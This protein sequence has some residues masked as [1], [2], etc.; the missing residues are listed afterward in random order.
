MWEYRRKITILHTF[1][2]SPLS[3][4]DPSTEV[5]LPTQNPLDLTSS[6]GLRL[7][8][9]PPSYDL[10]R[11]VSVP[12]VSL[13]VPSVVVVRSLTR[14]YD[15]PEWTTSNPST[16]VGPRVPTYPQPDDYQPDLKITDLPRPISFPDSLNLLFY[17]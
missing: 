6:P 12:T 10:L 9:L 15:E 11:G 14:R 17:W 3:L 5:C 4:P 16:T 8:V 13:R 2:I 7:R 1:P